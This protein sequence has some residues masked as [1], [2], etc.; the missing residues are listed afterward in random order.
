MYKEIV[1]PNFEWVNFTEEEQRKILSCD[2]SNNCLDTTK[3]SELC[4][5]VNNIKVAVKKILYDMK[6]NLAENPA[7][8]KQKL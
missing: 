2:R 3:L 6:E 8:E 5:E 1:D 7:P 4:P